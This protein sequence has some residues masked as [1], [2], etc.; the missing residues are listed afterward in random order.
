MLKLTPERLAALLRAESYG[1]YASEAATELL[2][3]HHRW[4]TRPDFIANCVGWLDPADHIT[5]RLPGPATERAS[6]MWAKVPAFVDSVAASTTEANVLRLAAELAGIDT[7]VA[8]GRLLVNLDDHNGPRVADAITHVALRGR[9]P[10][11]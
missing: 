8:L 10:A 11:R 6:I 7:G 5:L 4:L 1:S 2:I 9:R 3:E